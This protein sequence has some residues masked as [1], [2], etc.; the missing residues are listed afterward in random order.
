MF[1]R[2]VS[3]AWAP[4]ES[5]ARAYTTGRETALPRIATA[6]MRINVRAPNLPIGRIPPGTFFICCQKTAASVYA[7][8]ALSIGEKFRWGCSLTG[9]VACAWEIP[10]PAGENA[11]F[12]DDSEKVKR[13]TFQTAPLPK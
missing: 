9:R 1:S 8:F 13:K 11:G 4:A 12:R 7:N 10:Q 5:S 2:Q 6:V 3:C